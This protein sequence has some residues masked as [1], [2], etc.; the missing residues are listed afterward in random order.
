M[1]H[2]ATAGILTGRTGTLVCTWLIDSDQFESAQV[3]LSFS[4]FFFNRSTMAQHKYHKV[5]S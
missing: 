4:F 3:G 2:N 5:W 1:I